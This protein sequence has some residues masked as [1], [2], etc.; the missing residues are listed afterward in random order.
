[1]DELPVGGGMGQAEMD[2][3][4]ARL[5]DDALVLR[6]DLEIEVSVHL[7]SGGRVA[8]QPDRLRQVLVGLVDNAMRHTPQGGW[9]RLM[10]REESTTARITVSD[11]GEGIPEDVLPHVFERFYRGEAAR[12]EGQ[13]AG[14]GLAISKQVVERYGGQIYVRSAVGKGT[15]V[16]IVLPLVG[17]GRASGG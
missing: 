10:A 5:R 1:V 2:E 16:V 8:I 11:S 13:G 6:P 14:L 17:Q 7:T 15:T 12:R 9:I 3:M 4:F